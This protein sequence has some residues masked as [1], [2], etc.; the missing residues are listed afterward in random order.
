MMKNSKL[1]TIWKIL[2]IVAIA[3]SVLIMLVQLVFTLP[4]FSIPLPT[5]MQQFISQNKKFSMLYPNEWF[6]TE[7][8]PSVQ[9]KSLV[10]ATIAYI[11]IPPPGVDIV[12]RQADPSNSSLEE[13]AQEASQL[14]QRQ[15]KYTEIATRRVVSNNEEIILRDYTIEMTDSRLQ[16]S[17]IKR[18]RDNYRLHNKDGYILVFCSS[19]SDFPQM[20]PIF[21]RMIDSFSYLD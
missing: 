10:I 5:T 19:S 2:P 15:G 14:H 1:S 13:I 21:Q 17:I 7:I 3:F 9:S 20:E 18:C 6:L 11:K 12:I 4:P 8:P 16:M